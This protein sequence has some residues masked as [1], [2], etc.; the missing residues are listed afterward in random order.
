[1]NILEMKSFFKAPHFTTCILKIF[2]EKQL[3]F[4]IKLFHPKYFFDKKNAFN[5]GFS[6]YS[7]MEMSMTGQFSFKIIKKM[8]GK[9][10][11]ICH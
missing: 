6:S 4:N 11:A 2:E 7:Q 3:N 8:H 5:A 1:M 9:L 10:V